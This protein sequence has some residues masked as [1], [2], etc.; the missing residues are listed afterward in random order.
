VEALTVL[1]FLVVAAF[2]TEAGLRV[3]VFGAAALRSV[4]FGERLPGAYGRRSR[5]CSPADSMVAN[6]A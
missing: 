6:S 3:A 1:A 5:T 4:D 2:F